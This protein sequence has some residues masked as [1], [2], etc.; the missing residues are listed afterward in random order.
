MLNLKVRLVAA[1]CVVVGLSAPAHDLGVDLGGT[2]TRQSGNN[3]RAGSLSVGVTGAYDFNDAWSISG[4]FVYTRDL[5]TRT[6]ESQS[7]GSNVFLLNLGGMWIPNDHLMTMLSVVGSPPSMQQNAS[8]VP[9]RAGDSID[10][11]I[12]SRNSSI[13]AIWNGLWTSGGFS[14]FEHTIDASAG[15][16]R[17]GVQQQLT[18]PNSI[19]SRLIQASCNAGLEAEI[20][21]LLAGVSS[22]LTQARFTLGYTATLFDKTDIGVE[23]ALF[24]YDVPP[25]SVGYYSLVAFNQTELGSGVPILPLQATLKGHASHKFGR[26]TVRLSYQWGLYTEGLGTLHV[27]GLRV[28][29]K[30]TDH[31]RLSL[32]VTGQGD[33][34]GGVF[35]NGGSQALLGLAYV[36]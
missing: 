27:L 4:L 25:S 32:N 30:V 28:G 23:G 19:R 1:M 26:V 17:F 24:L 16:S 2:F 10:V 36:W 3:P 12:T 6:A 29:W 31:W 13:G 35:A 33:V 9:T 18:I 15:V 21:P 8:T 5:A 11:V 34:Q 14:N 20:C 22:P 7:P